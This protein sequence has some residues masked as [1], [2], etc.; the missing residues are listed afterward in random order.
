MLRNLNSHMAIPMRMVQICAI[1]ASFLVSG[2]GVVLGVPVALISAGGSPLSAPADKQDPR[3]YELKGHFAYE[4]QRYELSHYWHCEHTSDFVAYDERRPVWEPSQHFAYKALPNGALIAFSLP[5]VCKDEKIE[6]YVTDLRYFP[7]ISNQCEYFLYRKETGLHQEN[8]LLRAMF[9]A[10]AESISKHK[11][12]MLG[13]RESS[14]IATSR[15]HSKTDPYRYTTVWVDGYELSPDVA[16]LVIDMPHETVDEGR[17]LYVKTK[18]RE[19]V[20][21]VLKNNKA[22]LKWRGRTLMSPADGVWRSSDNQNKEIY[23]NSRCFPEMSHKTEMPIWVDMA[24]VKINSK[25]HEILFDRKTNML[26]RIV[27][28]IGFL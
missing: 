20:N 10:R 8:P 9:T 4:G 7:D 25:V 26:Y 13:D 21:L 3:Y 19:G 22:K 18:S 17:L 11:D 2:C 16:L 14:F 15:Q 24:G 1:G 5:R 28:P 6:S 23:L 27:T 12:T